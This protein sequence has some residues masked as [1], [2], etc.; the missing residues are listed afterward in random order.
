MQSESGK[1]INTSEYGVCH[2]I[3]NSLEKIPPDAKEADVL[4]LTP[5]YK[6]TVSYKP[7]F[8]R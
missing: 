7:W 3:Y 6:V 2:V 5:I 4:C 8:I 1:E